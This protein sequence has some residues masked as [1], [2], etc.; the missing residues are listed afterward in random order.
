MPVIIPIRD[1][2][3]TTEISELAHKTR[4]PIFVTR[5]GYSD[6][7]VMSSETYDRFAQIERVD[8]II[9]NAEIEAANGAEL[10]T[11]DQAFDMLDKKYYG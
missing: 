1:L 9:R 11:V 7:V 10:I 2:R 6:L 8:D 4:E 5:N 3:K